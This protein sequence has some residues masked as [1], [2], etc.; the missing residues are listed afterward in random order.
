MWPYVHRI[1][2][3]RSHILS[4]LPDFVSRKLTPAVLIG[5]LHQ[6]FDHMRDTV[7]TKYEDDI[8]ALQ[9][10]GNLFM[11]AVINCTDRTDN[12]A[13]VAAVIQPTRTAA[14]AAAPTSQCFNCSGKDLATGRLLAD[15]GYQWRDR[16]PIPRSPKSKPKPDGGAG[17]LSGR[18]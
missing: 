5:N 6:R 10:V 12:F 14:R 15:S 13:P 7:T 11:L 1:H 9:N 8:P 18:A 3:A 16:A 17:A 4:I 2:S